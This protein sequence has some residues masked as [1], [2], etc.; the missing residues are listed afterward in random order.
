M[1]A[2]HILVRKLKLS[3]YRTR[4][5]GCGS[6]GALIVL[7]A[8]GQHR[9]EEGMSWPICRSSAAICSGRERRIGLAAFPLLAVVPQ[10]IGVADLDLQHA[11]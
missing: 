11:R 8:V 1:R 2:R 5:W 3:S 6:H 4:A 9:I 10:E 7:N